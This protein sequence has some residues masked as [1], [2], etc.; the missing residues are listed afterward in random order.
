MGQPPDPPKGQRLRAIEREIRLLRARL[1]EALLMRGHNFAL[2]ATSRRLIGEIDARDRKI[3]L[4]ET[5]LRE[6]RSKP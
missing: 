4:L 1:D 3:R 2:A 5:L 6:A